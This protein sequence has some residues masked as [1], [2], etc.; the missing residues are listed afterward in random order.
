MNP[1]L[2]AGISPEEALERNNGRLRLLAEI[3]GSLLMAEDPR[4]IIRGIFARLSAHLKLEI[5]FN[6]VVAEEG[7]LLRLDSCGGV[8]DVEAERLR[9]LKFGEAVCGAVALRRERMVCENVQ[10]G[11]AAV[12]EHV[13]KAG[14]SAYACFPLVSGGRLFGTL[15]FGT[16]SRAFFQEDELDLMQTVA[17]QAAVAV[18]R[19][20]T[21]DELRRRGAELEERAHMLE[22]AHVIV[23]DLEGVVRFWNRGAEEMYG[24]TR[25]EAQGRRVDELLR[26]EFPQ[27]AEEIRRLVV[28]QGKWTGE[29]VQTRR[30][31]TQI[32]VA[33][34]WVL[35]RGE[36]GAPVI[37]EVDN[38]VTGLRE[39]EAALRESEE[40]YRALTEFLPVLVY[41]AT[42]E[43]Q[44]DFVNKHWCDYTGLDAAEGVGRKWLSTVHPEDREAVARKWDEAVSGGAVFEAQYR[45]RGKDGSYRWFLSRSLPLRD[46][47]GRVRK[48]FGTAMDIEEHKRMEEAVRRAQKAESIGVLAGGIAHRFN[49]LLTGIL[50][51]ATVAMDSLPEGSDA[52][53]LLEGVVESSQRAAELTGQLLAYAGKGRYVEEAVNLTEVVDGLK[54]LLET[55]VS[56]KVRLRVELQRDLPPV[57]AD[58][59]QMRQVVLGL[60]MNAAE[61]IGEGTGTV[62]VKTGTTRVKGPLAG[63]VTDPLPPGEYACLEVSD[64]G[65][66]MDAATMARIFDP[67]FTT[68]F[69]GRGL[70]LPASL[71]IVRAQKGAIQYESSPGQGSRFRVLLPVTEAADGRRSAGQ[72]EAPAVL[73]VDDEEIVRITARAI[74]E[75]SGHRVLLAENGVDALE[76]LSKAGD[77]IVLVLLDMAMPVMGGE[78]V[79]QKLRLLRPHLPVLVSTGYDESEAVRRFAGQTVA[80]FVQKPFTA[81][82]LAEKVAEALAGGASAPPA[83][84]GAGGQGPGAG[85]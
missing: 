27:P 39:T 31:G 62:Q 50:G 46:A 52:R 75:R 82:Q 78:E 30:D 12:V 15:S 44:R 48:W 28:E 51:G 66:G 49:N 76:T 29:L 56:R 35:H 33:S 25:E 45:V 4:E 22:L 6:Y 84:P 60:V 11:G 16:R 9:W 19:R 47:R 67:F 73:V 40:R 8:S 34:H 77:E 24:W 79:M 85:D 23:H 38:D 65:S 37:M 81:R 80:G 69:M 1:R 74:L 42:P 5:Y 71:G 18:E 14:I 58:A 26:T 64:T 59:G 53:P 54:D 7:R 10:A 55:G 13:R 43:G 32:V 70:G 57:L 3:A 68:K 20:H 36:D 63:H 21:Q 41:T 2:E 83:A 72:R 61:S 17:S